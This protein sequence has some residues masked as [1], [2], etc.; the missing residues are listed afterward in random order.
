VARKLDLDVEALRRELAG[1]K[2]ARVEEVPP[3]ADEPGEEPGFRREWRSQRPAQIQRPV[4]GARA[5]QRVQAV[6]PGPAVDALGL[7]IA[8]P[9]LA[10]VAADEHLPALLPA[11]PLAELA[12]DLIREPLPREA[13]LARL[14][15]AAEPLRRRIEALVGPGGV[16]RADAERLLRKAALTASIA[17]VAEQQERC[18]ARVARAGS[19]VPDEL[20]IEAETAMR[21][22]ADLEKRLRGLARS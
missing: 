9:D 10:P 2:P 3:E 14:A 20:R 19:P 15:E 17:A 21:R 1:V 12:R 6:L 5:G 22:R 4:Q 8:F 16:E 18:N 11:G 13:A 7:L